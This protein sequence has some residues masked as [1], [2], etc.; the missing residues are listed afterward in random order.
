[1]N[2]SAPPHA[3]IVGLYLPE[4]DEARESAREK[5]SKLDAA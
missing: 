4:A 2:N 1:M 5:F 3:S